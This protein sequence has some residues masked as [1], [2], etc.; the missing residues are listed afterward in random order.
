MTALNRMKDATA[1]VG[2]GEAGYERNLKRSYLSMGAEAA[3]QAVRDAGLRA[4]DI[5]G[6]CGCAN[7]TYEALQ[8][9][10]GIPEVT[11][12]TNTPGH[13]ISPQSIASAAHAVHSGACETALVVWA[14]N[15]PVGSREAAND[16]IR[17]AAAPGRRPLSDVAELFT[18]SGEAYSAW[19]GR[20][21]HEYGVPRE[22]LGLIAINSRTNAAAEARAAFK[23]PLTMDDYLASRW[24]REPF[25]LLDMEVPVD[26]GNAF[27][28]TTAE[29]ARELSD[30]PVVIHSNTMGMSARGPEHYESAVDYLDLATWVVSR[31]LWE[32][33]EVERDDIDVIFPYDG[34]TV[35]SLAWYEALGYCGP[36]EGYDFVRQNW[37][38]SEQ[39]LKIGGRT[40]AHPM[41]GSLSKG[42][43]QG[44]SYFHEAVRQLRGTSSNQVSGAKTALLAVG[45]FFQNSSGTILRVE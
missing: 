33:S 21:M 42:G 8:E 39:R 5:D 38:E 34:Y 45:G 9:T 22:A 13:L 1:I 31:A 28:I 40:L 2:I 26:S 27:V 30:R 25:K 35:I 37:C 11:W 19:T 24:I 6:I 32:K 36:G 4:T 29:R 10:L 43:S 17:V 41:G 18:Q 3:K 16:P 12:G 14:T 44:A 20:Y 7:V 15:H 23:A